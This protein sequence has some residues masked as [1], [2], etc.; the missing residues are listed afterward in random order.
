MKA[1]PIC[2]FCSNAYTVWR[3]TATP[4]EFTLSVDGVSL[5]VL[6]DSDGQWAA[7]AVCHDLIEQDH[8][9]ALLA[10][11]LVN[12]YETYPQVQCIPINVAVQ[13]IQGYHNTFF[14][15]KYGNAVPILRG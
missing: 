3:Y 1:D 2:D 6:Q 12:Q 4:S 10:R 8:R 11:S 9:L 7:C 14:S 15:H 13:F 5:L